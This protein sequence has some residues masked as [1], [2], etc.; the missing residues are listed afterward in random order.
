MMEPMPTPAKLVTIITGFEGQD[1]VERTLASFGVRGYTHV[2]AKGSGIHGAV[3][4]GVFEA[5]NVIFTI[6]ASEA[7]ATKILEWVE[8]ELAEAS[9]TVAYT[10]DVMTTENGH[11]K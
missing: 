7:T 9:P 3:P 4:D 2:K 8:R 6:L 5:G 11:F 10:T 1:T